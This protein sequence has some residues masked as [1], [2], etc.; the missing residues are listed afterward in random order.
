MPL[1]RWCGAIAPGGRAKLTQL[2]PQILVSIVDRNAFHPEAARTRTRTLLFYRGVGRGGQELSAKRPRR[3]ALAAAARSRR[4]FGPVTT[5]SHSYAGFALGCALAA[6]RWACS[7]APARPALRPEVSSRTLL[8]HGPCRLADP[9]ADCPVALHGRNHGG[10]LGRF[11]RLFVANS[12][13]NLH[14]SDLCA[15]LFRDLAPYLAALVLLGMD[16]EVQLSGQ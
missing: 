7:P 13:P 3:S 10:G 9:A 15:I 11:L 6:F 8:R 12:F 4:E 14:S 16:V 1:L 2:I 5:L